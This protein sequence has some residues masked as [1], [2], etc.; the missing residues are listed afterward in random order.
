[1]YEMRDISM[2]GYF[3][4]IP[5][6]SLIFNSFVR[7]VLFP[8]LL[9]LL[10][11]LLLFFI[12]EK[13]NIM[14]FFLLNYW[15]DKSHIS[16]VASIILDYKFNHDSVE[17]LS[18]GN[19]IT[20]VTYKELQERWADLFS[21]FY[22]QYET[23]VEVITFPEIIAFNEVQVWEKAMR[24]LKKW[25]EQT[26]KKYGLIIRNYDLKGHLNFSKININVNG[27]CNEKLLLFNPTQRVLLTIFFNENA[28]T[29]EQEA[30][31]CIDEVNL[32]SL[33][34]REE[35][36]DSDMMVA[37]IVVCSGENNHDKCLHCKNFIVSS[38][39]FNSVH[40]FNSFWDDYID[41][42][43]KKSV[44]NDKGDSGSRKVFKAV[45]S[46]LLGFL[47]HYQ[48]KMFDQAVLPYP[49]KRPDEKVFLTELL[50]NRYQ[51]EIVYSKENHIFLTGSYGTGKTIVICKKI[52]LLQRHLKD[53]ESIY[54]VNF[55]EKSH[56]DS[57]LVTKMKLHE[58]VKVIK[59][60]FDLSYI[61]KN[62]ILPNERGRGKINLMVDE[63][64]TQSLSQIE[65]A[66]LTR[67]FK[68][69]SQF[70]NSTIF[71]AVQPIEISRTVKSKSKIMSKEKHMVHDLK[72][73]MY[74][75]NLK[76]IMRT[77]VEIYTLAR[78]TEDYLNGKS[79]RYF[80]PNPKNDGVIAKMKKEA[81]FKKQNSKSHSQK[82]ID[83]D[84]LYKLADTSTN[85]NYKRTWSVVTSYRYNLGSNI[86]HN[87]HGR[88]PK[89]F[90]I[91]KSVD[92]LEQLALISLFLSSIVENNTKHI[93]IVHF[94]SQ[95]PFWLTYLLQLTN[96]NRLT[97]TFDATEFINLDKDQH[98]QK[99]GLVLVADYRCVKGLEFSNVLL[100]LNEHEYYL[101]HFIPE[102][103]TRC[104]SNLSIL[105]V[106][107]NKEIC[108][109][110]TVSALVDKWEE[111]NN[112][113][114]KNPILEIVELKFCSNPI[115]RIKMN[116]FCEFGGN[117]YMHKFTKFFGDLYEEI[118]HSVASNL[119]SDNDEEKEEAKSL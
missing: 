94:G 40:H 85:E 76:Y 69:K 53:N 36:I 102:A 78:I 33:L 32:L 66:E 97:I 35:L 44:I 16:T 4:I 68:K 47:A 9:L 26:S 70:K 98:K 115:C 83:H 88:L 100:L 82:R 46:K 57:N 118:R 3:P 24:I 17:L 77:T 108:Q 80:L 72:E 117:K 11:L 114:N 2:S 116:N 37:G 103:M 51:M 27:E 49:K 110:E 87:I 93:A 39:I 1:M 81:C 92:H 63:Y 73:S 19:Q 58:K 43:I 65:A 59:G 75:Y 7:F 104:M 10:L 34:L 29:L 95:A 23:P 96:F 5:R 41:Q 18:G 112:M 67:I 61:I 13:R 45:A 107:R 6:L 106:P 99:E 42:E 30:F 71:I 21:Q 90:K 109:S 101:K 48:F 79:N 25:C 14:D 113:S 38:D 60:G 105:I 86:G 64:D 31:S 119:K 50:L 55:E 15:Q 62:K 12:L 89:L 22:T 56:L 54:Y 20:T 8:L 91:S 74:S 84:L 28:E 52:E 111:V